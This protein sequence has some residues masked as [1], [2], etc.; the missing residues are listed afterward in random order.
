MQYYSLVC[1]CVCVCGSFQTPNMTL[2]LELGQVFISSHASL[3]FAA[4]KE[5]DLPKKV[6]RG[7]LE[8]EIELRNQG[9]MQERTDGRRRSIL[10]I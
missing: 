10:L 9:G 1:V 5:R 7:G 3:P 4:N 6:S 2:I 8:L